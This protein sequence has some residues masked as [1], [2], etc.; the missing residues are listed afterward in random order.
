MEILFITHKYPPSV[1]GMEK[2]SYELI[3]GAAK[4]NKVHTLIYDNKTSR[5][6]FLLT[7]PMKVKKILKENPGISIIHLNDGLMGLCG[8]F[9]KRITSLPVLMTLHGLDIVLPSNIYQNRVVG[10]F[11][12]L[13]GVIAVSQATA[14]ECIKRGFDRDKVYVV[15]NGVDTEMSLINKK[16]GFRKTL[17][18]KLGIPL[19]DKKILVSIGRSVRR[20][21]FSWFMTR[22]LPQLDPNIIYLIVGPTDPNIRRINFFMNLLPKRIAHIIVLALGLGL[23]EIDVQEALGRDEIKGRAFYLG[24]QPFEDMVQILKHSDMFVMPNIKVAGDAEGFGLVALEASVNGTPVIASSLEGITCAVIDGK[25][26][27]LV[28]PENEAAWI[29]KIHSLLSD[30]SHLKDFGEK[31]QQ[32]T[33]TNFAWKKMVEGYLTVFKK[34]HFQQQCQK[35]PLQSYGAGSNPGL[36]GPMVLDNY[37]K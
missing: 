10:W 1:G 25:N 29:E 5:M 33:I 7:V 13:D 35:A 31:A 11:K 21:G 24:K 26:G 3:N 17:E 36:S 2:Q 15:R 30:T 6:K 37:Y 20:K 14:Q 18:A 22:I 12:K 32:F 19:H 4:T 34:Y 8:I 23:D 27:F 9:I 16:A 28:P